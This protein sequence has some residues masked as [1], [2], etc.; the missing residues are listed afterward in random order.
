MRR[1]LRWKKHSK[2]DIFLLIIL[3]VV[4]IMILVCV[5]RANTLSFSYDEIP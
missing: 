3:I 1:L 5:H 4:I 2:I